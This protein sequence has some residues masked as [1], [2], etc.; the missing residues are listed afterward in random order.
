MGKAF[1][2][3]S[4]T[5]FAL[6]ALV[7]CL[8]G[9][10]YLMGKK[11]QLEHQLREERSTHPRFDASFA[12]GCFDLECVLCSDP[13]DAIV[14]T[15]AIKTGEPHTLIW[16]LDGKE[17]Q[18]ASYWSPH[19]YSNTSEV[20]LVVTPRDSGSAIAVLLNKST[21]NSFHDEHPWNTCLKEPAGNGYGSGGYYDQS[22]EPKMLIEWS[23]THTAALILQFSANK[24]KVE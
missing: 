20:S 21:R 24:S 4:L 5:L 11:L 13:A 22:S 9:Y 15:F 16:R 7:A 17:T 8:C 2:I 23:G 18:Y 1:Q 14:Y 3:N 19:T 10:V 12:N 6:T